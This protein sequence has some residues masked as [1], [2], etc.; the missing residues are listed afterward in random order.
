MTHEKCTQANIYRDAEFVELFNQTLKLL[1]DSRCT[2]PRRDAVRF[3][4][5]NAMPR[6]D[7]SLK[8]ACEAV[9]RVLR[10]LPVTHSEEREALWHEMATR[11]KPLIDAGVSL[12]RAVD[13]VLT[14][15]RAG[16]IFLDEAY[17]YRYSYRVQRRRRDRLMRRFKVS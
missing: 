10:G 12:T 11:V 16:R 14:H 15:C 4:L 7:V 1:I 5:A 8:R 6:Y 3:A 13:H 2:A 9:S 17:A